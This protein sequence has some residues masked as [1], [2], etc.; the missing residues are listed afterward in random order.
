MVEQ[1]ECYG[2]AA[3]SAKLPDTYVPYQPDISVRIHTE[4]YNAPVVMSPGEVDALAECLLADVC[5]AVSNRQED[6]EQY[7]SMLEYFCIAWRQV[8]LLHGCESSGWGDYQAILQRVMKMNQSI[9]PAML[10]QSNRSG[11]T[12]TFYTLIL[13]AAFNPNLNH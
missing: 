6:V 10:L 2:V 7:R 11:A 4:K 3:A 5:A 13:Q 9:N 8:W 1:S 12:R